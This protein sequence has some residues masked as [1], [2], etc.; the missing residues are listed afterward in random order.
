MQQSESACNIVSS[1]RLWYPFCLSL[2]EKIITVSILVSRSTSA[3]KTSPCRSVT[4]AE[5][6]L[7]FR[8]HSFTAFSFKKKWSVTSVVNGF[9]DAHH[10]F[11]VVLLCCGRVSCMN[12]LGSRNSHRQPLASAALLAKVPV[13]K[14]N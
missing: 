9:N 1:C 13:H 2:C 3:G 6:A 14:M 11:T 5:T 10:F 12:V 8:H 7:C 4:T